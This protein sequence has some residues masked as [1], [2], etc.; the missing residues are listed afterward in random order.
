MDDPD[1]PQG[2]PLFVPPTGAAVE[3]GGPDDDAGVGRGGRGG[4]AGPQPRVILRFAD[5]K[6]LL[7]SGMLTG[8][9][10]LAGHPA[11]IDCQKGKGHVLMFANNPMWRSETHGSYF[12]LFNAMLNFQHLDAGR[13]V[14]TGRGGRG[15]Q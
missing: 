2:R 6:D 5:E 9:S 3:G 14:G 7:V 15:A 12:L 4:A 1:I 10:A 8:G 13:A 11:V